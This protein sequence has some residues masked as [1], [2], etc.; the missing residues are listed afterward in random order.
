MIRSG[1]VFL[2]MQPHPEAGLPS[3]RKAH[4]YDTEQMYRM[5]VDSADDFAIFTMDMEGRF[6]TWNAGA[7]RIFGFSEAEILGQDISLIFTNEDKE[8]AIPQREIHD[9]LTKGKA[10]DNRWHIRK[11]SSRFWADGLMMPLQDHLEVTHGF[12]KIVRDRTKY[13]H[14]EERLDAQTLE[15]RLLQEEMAELRKRV[16]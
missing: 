12:L 2:Q 3:R 7:E 16:G 1:C 10:Q 11:D 4:V 13:K 9:S 5:I 14:L 15:L 6:T 8:R